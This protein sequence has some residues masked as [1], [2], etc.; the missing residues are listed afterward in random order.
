MKFRKVDL[1][2]G[3]EVYAFAEIGILL[4]QECTRSQRSAK[5]KKRTPVNCCLLPGAKSNAAR[6]MTPYAKASCNGT[7]NIIAHLLRRHPAAEE[8]GC[9][10]ITAMAR[11]RR[12]HHVRDAHT[13]KRHGKNS[14]T[15]SRLRNCSSCSFDFVLFRYPQHKTQNSENSNKITKK[16][17]HTFKKLKRKNIRI[18][19]T[20]NTHIYIYIYILERSARQ[21]RT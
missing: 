18:T 21:R 5:C 19:K 6:S 1:F 9:S 11:V 10:E 15:F 14:R 4:A 3:S 7:I 8:T 13:N 2:W 17:K 20:K 12:A 16:T